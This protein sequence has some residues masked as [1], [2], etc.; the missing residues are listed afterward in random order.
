MFNS[1]GGAP[2]PQGLK[3]ATFLDIRTLPENMAENYQIT[4]HYTDADISGIDESSLKLYFWSSDDNSW[5]LCN[6]IS[7][8]TSAKT[9]SGSIG[10]LTPFGIFG[11]QAAPP[12]PPAP[13][14][15]PRVG[16]SVSIS[17]S[18]SSALPGERINYTVTV[19]N[20]GDATDTFDLSISGGT[21]WFPSISMGS[22]TLG[23]GT[24]STGTLTV[25]VPSWATA[26][27]STTITII[28]T[29]R[30]DSTVSSSASCKATASAPLPGP[31]GPTPTPTIISTSG[32]E[33]L[34]IAGALLA[35]ILLS[36][37]ILFGFYRRRKKKS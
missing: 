32:V 11:V 24:A 37:F 36:L 23:A 14:A 4:F 19:M 34:V 15:A 22:I 31:P 1:I 12:A 13:P 6:N 5:H 29:S 30:A 10:H 18:T 9:V 28:A 26:G 8:N 21:G 35:I 17:P 33:M 2:I 27:D 16:V 7:V 3:V 20:T 25:T